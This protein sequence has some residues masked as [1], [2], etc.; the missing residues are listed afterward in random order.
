LHSHP[1]NKIDS[2]GAIRLSEA[3]KSNSSLTLL[4]LEGTRLDIVFT[5]NIV[6]EDIDIKTMNQI[7]EY[8]NRNKKMWEEIRDC[9]NTN[10]LGWLKTLLS[11]PTIN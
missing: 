11:K 10:D 6:D 7:A 4:D 3:L 2:V 1:G 8:I 9:I 5:L